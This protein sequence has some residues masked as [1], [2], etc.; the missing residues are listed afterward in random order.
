MSISKQSLQLS[1]DMMLLQSQYN[2]LVTSNNEALE[3][4]II[5]ESERNVL[6][7]N[8]KFLQS[9]LQ[10]KQKQIKTITAKS[11]AIQKE[12]SKGCFLN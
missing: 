4:I 6:R 8:N 11:E 9:K 1:Q 10:G 5:L 12:C 3:R 7:E 2:S